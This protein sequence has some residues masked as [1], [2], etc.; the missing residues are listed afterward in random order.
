MPAS[1]DTIGCDVGG[2]SIQFTLLEGSRP[3]HP[4]RVPTPKERAGFI[5]ELSAAVLRLVETTG[6]GR[7]R[8]TAIGVGFCG[9]L[10]ER[11]RSIVRS[12]HLPALNGCRLVS[13][14]ERRTRLSVTL[15]TDTN[16]G[17]VAEA[18]LG[19]G[20][21]HSRA[22]Y[23]SLGTGL[24]A[25][26]VVGRRPVR[27]S[28][29]T[30]GQISEVLINDVATPPCQVR[31]AESLLSTRGILAR[32]RRRGLR[33]LHSTADLFA[34]AQAGDRDARQVWLETGQILGR[35]LH[36]LV[37]LWAPDVVIIGG[38]TAGAAELFLKHAKRQMKAQRSKS[39]KLPPLKAASQGPMAGAI[40]AALLARQAE[41]RVPRQRK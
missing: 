40:G 22:L 15:D 27:V 32:A 39:E 13:I 3:L 4:L 20:R 24:G 28:Y 12:T 11:R 29:H 36:T 1:P 19:A 41:E 7:P 37:S 6:R 8:P 2:A 35:L 30:V 16:A 31:R 10:D 9:L 25:A 26:L 33:R 23:V 21:G 34:A 18:T 17:A 14:L 5:E 38:G